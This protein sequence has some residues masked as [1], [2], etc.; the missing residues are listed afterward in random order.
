MLIRDF[1]L[2]VNVVLAGSGIL[3]VEMSM[4]DIVLRS[5]S[6]V[7]E[8][9]ISA[10]GKLLFRNQIESLPTL[11]Y[12]QGQADDDGDGSGK[13]NMDS[14]KQC[15]KVVTDS[16]VILLLFASVREREAAAGIM[17]TWI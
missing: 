5:I 4:R 9:G 7:Y 8:N 15:L 10:D 2:L 6:G 3:A 13:K 1:G 12:E 16:G 17:K 11:E 14:E